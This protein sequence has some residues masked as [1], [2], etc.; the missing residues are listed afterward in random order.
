MVHKNSQL[1]IVALSLGF[2]HSGSE[3]YFRKS[4]LNLNFV[5]PSAPIRAT[6]T[7]TDI[8]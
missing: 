7:E 2:I 1:P 8:N 6:T 5:S 4:A 3:I